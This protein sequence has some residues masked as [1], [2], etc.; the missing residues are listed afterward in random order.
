M[1]RGESHLISTKGGAKFFRNGVTYVCG[2]TPE[3]VPVYMIEVASHFSSNQTQDE[4]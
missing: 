3:G 1:E 4:L 2:A